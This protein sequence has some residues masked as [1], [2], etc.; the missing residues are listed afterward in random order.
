MGDIGKIVLPLSCFVLFLIQQEVGSDLH[1]CLVVLTY[2]TSISYLIAIQYLPNLH[3]VHPKACDILPLSARW[4]KDLLALCLF[5]CPILSD[6]LSTFFLDFIQITDPKG[7][8]AMFC[9]LLKYSYP[10]RSSS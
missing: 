2:F 1:W 4:K 9:V 3:C 6:T 5:C 10:S 7:I 8:A